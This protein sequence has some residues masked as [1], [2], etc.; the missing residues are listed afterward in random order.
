MCFAGHEA[1]AADAA[2]DQATAPG[3]EAEQSSAALETVIVTAQKRKQD[4]QTVPI[5][6]EVLGQ[7]QLATY[8]I[9]DIQSMQAY[10]PNLLVQSATA[11]QQYFIRGFGSQAAND[12]FEQSVSVYV[13]GIYGGRNRQF[14]SPFFDA[15]QVEVL[16]GPQGALLGKNTAAGAIMIT[17]ANPTDTFQAASDLTYSFSRPGENFFGYVSGPL[18]DGINSRVA[19]H[20]EDMQGWIDNTGTGNHD[21]SNHTMQVRPSIEFKPAD[22]VDVIA[23]LDYNE[24]Y[25][26]GNSL[27]RTSTTG[28]TVTTVKDEPPPFGIPE[29]DRTTATNG[30]VTARFQ[31]P[32]GTLESITGYSGYDNT[33]QLGAL[34][35]APEVFNVGFVSDFSQ[36]SEEL[37]FLS[38][39]NQPLEYIVGLYYD[40]S[41]FHTEN[42]ST[43]NFGYGFAGQ[44]RTV[45]GQHANTASAFGAAT[46]HVTDSFRVLGSLRY[47]YENKD[48]GFEELTDYGVPIATAPSLTGAESENH[49]DPSI[50]LQ[51]DIA[52]DVMVYALFGQGSK[53]GGF[54]S[55]TRTVVASDFEYKPEKSKSYEAGIKST[56]FDKRALLDVALYDTKFTDLQVTTFDPKLI[57]YITGNA[58]AA[59]S[60]GVEFS[61]AGVLSSQFKITTSGAYLNAVYDNFPGAQCLATTPAAECSPEGTTNLAGTTVLGASRWTG[62]VALDFTQPLNNSW[63]LTAT[64]DANYRSGYF[65][66]ANESPLYGYQPGFVKY[67]GNISLVKNGWTVSLLG[68]NLGNKLTKNFSYDFAGTGVAAIDPTRDILLEVRYKY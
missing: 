15:D 46:W 47:T 34:A 49:V 32:A 60:K 61:L 66:S 64:V 36:A 63:L 22:G 35:G 6:M 55:S 20:L 16:R 33:Y 50:T 53:G 58:A 18:S 67:D 10:V 30:S 59:T 52:P 24:I 19:L 11:P 17:T 68:K 12:A 23:K 40:G 3:G 13:D 25:L 29:V 1:L 51:Y 7:Q 44:V 14:M 26:D 28:Y 31:L 42:T 62:N 39:T 56:F 43:Y 9:T 2:A 21:P 4:V 41:S 57:T 54:V 37:R 48:A 38:P 65:I 27:V 5:S 45:Y 8:N